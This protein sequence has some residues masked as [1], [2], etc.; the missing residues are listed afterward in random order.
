MENLKKIWV[1]EGYDDFLKNPEK[2]REL[3]KTKAERIRKENQAAINKL[4]LLGQMKSSV[5]TEIV[6]SIEASSGGKSKESLRS[7]RNQGIAEFCF[8]LMLLVPSLFLNQWSISPFEFGWFAPLISL[9]ISIIVVISLERMLALLTNIL[10]ERASLIWNLFIVTAA[11]VFGT[12]AV[13]YLSRV[14]NDL[15]VLTMFSHYNSPDFA[16]AVQ[17]FYEKSLGVLKGVFPLLTLGL[18]LTAAV[19]LHSA[20]SK[21]SYAVPILGSHRMLEHTRKE[22]I[23]IASEIKTRES[24]PEVFIN[25]YMEGVLKA[26]GELKKKQSIKKEGKPIKQPLT[27]EDLEMKRARNLTIAIILFIILLLLL[28][29]AVGAFGSETALIGLDIT[30]SNSVKDYTGISEFEK[31]LQGVKRVIEQ[32]R[33]GS[34][35]KAYAIHEESYSKPYLLFEGKIS[36]KPGYFGQF[37]QRDIKSLLDKWDSLSKTLKP[38]A[39]QTDIIGFLFLAQELFECRKGE[40][41]LI[42][43]SDMRHTKGINLE[44]PDVVESSAVEKAKHLFGVPNLKGVKIYVYGAHANGKSISYSASLKRFWSDYLK[45]SNGELVVFSPLREVNY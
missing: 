7:M 37:R 1:K 24:V 3:C 2:I 17:K 20:V 6:K 15:A 41:V 10:P 35:L 26:E 11:G 40:K 31:N 27:P 13:L 34:E 44:K 38:S 9:G 8:S 32:A 18:D 19:L 43:F 21:L 45:Q 25:C 30:G 36:E 4:T 23:N 28:I 33:Q 16:S 12:A 29:Y 39:K 42:I 5:E 22:L 14:R